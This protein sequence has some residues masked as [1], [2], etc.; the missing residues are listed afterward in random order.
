MKDTLQPVEIRPDRK[1]AA[2]EAA[3]RS[4]AL[5][6]SEQLKSFLRYVCEK[7]LEGKASELT[8]YAIG[9]DALGRTPDFSPHEDSIVRNRAYA[10][11]KKLDEFYEGEGAAEP[12]RVELPKGSYVPKYWERG[13]IPAPVILPLRPAWRLPLLTGLLG[14][15]V[16]AAAIWLWQRDRWMPAPHAAMRQVWGSLVDGREPVLLCIATPAT[17]FLR[18][19]PIA[20]PK[21][22]GIYPV[23]GP[24][25]DWYRRMRKPEGAPYLFQV[26]TGNSPLWGDAA[27]AL[28]IGQNLTGYGIP[29]D[30]VAERLIALPALRNRGV[31]Y[32][33]TAEYSDLA[34]TLLRELPLQLRFDATAGDHVPLEVDA[35]G[36]ILQRFPVVRMPDELREVYGLLTFLPSEGD[37][38]RSRRS[39]V[40]SGITSA[41]TLAAAEFATSPV[42]LENLLRKS[43]GLAAGPKGILQVLVK[44]RSN[45]TLPLHF[46]YATHR[47]I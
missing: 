1:R 6:R 45:R 23:D 41:G 16:G 39:L 47:L 29:T 44:V 22:P 13:A 32:L 3:L 2:W 10:L 42:H 26:P 25:A 9:V 43:G 46:E 18:E 5:D 40:V 24:I 17:T 11:R 7:D 12:I 21:V 27:A 37:G 31:V 4:Q 33:A 28:R 38:Q 36:K 15:I 19:Y 8:E 14:L 20:K 30:M 35:G 34:K